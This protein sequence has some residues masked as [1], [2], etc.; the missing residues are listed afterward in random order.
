MQEAQHFSKEFCRK[1]LLDTAEI[2]IRVFIPIWVIMHK[3][4]FA[5]RIHHAGEK[6]REPGL[7]SR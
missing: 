1:S 4:M 6:P 5:E 2:D 7:H 3:K